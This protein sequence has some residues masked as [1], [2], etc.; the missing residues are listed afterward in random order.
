M[1]EETGGPVDAAALGRIFL[2]RR[3]V[4]NFLDRPV[5]D[6][7]LRRIYELARMPPTSSN[8]Q[9][10]RILFLKTPESR[11]RLAPALSNSNREKTMRAPVTGIVAYDLAFYTHLPRMFHTPGAE[12]WFKG[13]DASIRENSFRNGTLQAAYFLLAARAVGLDVGPMSGFDKAKVDAEFFSS[14]ERA[15]WRS[16]F[17]CNL[18]YGDPA[19]LHPRDPRFE[20]D[21]VC[22]TI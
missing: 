20:F 16:N 18:G 9:P 5:P 7:L 14:G 22:H 1:A 4:D 21:E 8:S 19:G 12:N 6:A 15:T 10:M 11:Q 2:D 3:S 13:N 17:V